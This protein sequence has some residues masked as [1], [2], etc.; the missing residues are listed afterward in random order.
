MKY[1]AEI[2][3]LRS[4]AVIPV[5]LF[6]AGSSLF[7]GGYAGVDIF[8]VISGYLI[9]TI[10]IAE[11]AGDGFSILRFYERRARRILPALLVVMAASIPGAL[12]LMLPD[13]LRDFA[14]S[15]VAV[16][17]FASNILFWQES[18]YFAP[19][20]ELKP[21]LHTW[22]LAI[23]E[24][25]YLFFPPLLIL[26]WGLGRRAVLV[27]LAALF[28][29]SLALAQVA[30]QAMPTANFYLLPTRAWELLAGSFC[31]FGYHRLRANQWL[32]ALGLLLIVATLFAYDGDTPF[33]SLYTVLPVA[34]AVL[35]ILFARGGTPTARLLALRPFVFVGLVSYSFYLW[36]QPL[37]A[38]ARIHA[39][40]DPA[41][42]LLY[43][44]GALAFLLAVLTW[45][46]VETPFRAR[47]HPAMPARR[48]LFGASAAG[49]GAFI[50]VGLAIV[51]TG[52]LAHR[53]SLDPALYAQATQLPERDHGGCFYSV[54]KR[55]ELPVGAE[56]LNCRLGDP[57]G[58]TR[59]LVFGDSFAGQY[60]PFWDSVGRE[61]GLDILSV[62]TNWCFPAL[63]ETFPVRGRGR[64]FRQCMLNRAW[65]SEN[66]DRFD[67][68]VFGGQWA[69]A[70]RQEQMNAVADAISAVLATPHTQ[71][72]F[73]PSPPAFYRLSVETSL[74][75]G[76][77]LLHPD[78]K[79]RRDAQAGMDVLRD[80]AAH[81]PRVDVL[82]QA[83]LFPE[84]RAPGLTA[85]GLP[86]ALDGAH[87]SLY[88]IRALTDAF[89]ATDTGLARLAPFFAPG[90]GEPQ[91]R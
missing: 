18:G 43:G 52:G 77:N 2:D 91:N 7:S 4:L 62:S 47:P 29:G 32:A 78:E 54:D 83:W 76:Q 88:G 84:S 89:L 9:T 41:P 20:A 58:D 68:I 59:V 37:F 49:A 50:L 35:V 42:G 33:P 61:M 6:H 53:S 46:F 72:V 44:L 27:S 82:D 51:F 80:I 23:E 24:Q 55:P 13:M 81:N 25:F 5:V 14:R 16:S 71:V 40:G 28:I 10:I 79:A 63:D 34:G 48:T 22:S 8:F 85:D 31:A 45:R 65:L 19:A 73:L 60:D 57:D 30:S 70:M 64:A 36:H 1:R 86:Y 90:T 87:V 66:L 67:T 17:L 74:F 26:L 15:L 11:L 21:L 12:W 69:T 3:G 56:G 39:G 75:R 38:F